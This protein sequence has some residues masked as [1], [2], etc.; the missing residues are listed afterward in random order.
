MV[1]IYNQFKEFKSFEVTFTNQKQ[2]L[3]KIFCTI[4]GIENDKLFLEAN[5]E[6]NKNI[7]ASVGD[8][9][10]IY[11]YTEN[12]IYSAVSRIIEAEKGIVN[13]KYII[14]YPSNTKHS[15]RREY[16]RAD[17][18]V[19]F[20]LNI[21]PKNEEEQ[22][23][24]LEGETRNL[25]GKGMSCILNTP[26]PEYN[27]IEVE[28]LFNEKIVD[29]SATLVYS[30]QLVLGNKPKFLHALAFTTIS[31]KNIDL[32]VKKCFVHQLGLRKQQRDKLV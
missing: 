27:S 16:F 10:K 18:Q 15:Q 9:L 30:K 13:T 17:L 11:I 20:N 21:T 5:N 12:G 1:D 29:T 3:Q 24:I 8:E 2:E 22:N 6:K 14:A 26:F 25:C 31:Q 19:K 28:L 7:F 4:K 23:L 32:I